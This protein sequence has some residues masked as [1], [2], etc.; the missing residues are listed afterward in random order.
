MPIIPILNY[1]FLISRFFSL[2]KTKQNAN[3]IVCKSF[4][5]TQR[6]GIHFVYKIKIL[7]ILTELIVFLKNGGKP[8]ISFI[9]QHLATTVRSTST[10]TEQY[11]M[12]GRE[13]ENRKLI[14]TFTQYQTAAAASVSSAQTRRGG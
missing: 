11:S 8:I 2:E 12:T 5:D 13:K 4:Y 14:F 6:I 7:F 1:F 10:M 9:F 3:S